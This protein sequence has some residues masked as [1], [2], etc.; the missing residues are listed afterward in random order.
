MEKSEREKHLDWCKERALQYL[1]PGEFYS[2]QDAFVSMLSD[3][4][5]HNETENH[6]GIEL[7]VMLSMGGFMQDEKQVREWITGFN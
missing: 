6:C 5:K 4:G 7:G 3:L 2:I 1:E